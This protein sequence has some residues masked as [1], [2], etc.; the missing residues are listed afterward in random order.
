MR[1]SLQDPEALRAI[2][3]AAVSAYARGADWNRH[4]LYREHSDVYVGETLPEIV[5][6]RTTRLGDSASVVAAL[7]ET[8]RR[9]PA[10]T[11]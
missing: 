4:G 8:F 2:S 11:S 6:P 7:V 1:V 5:V 9:L 10:R 3:P